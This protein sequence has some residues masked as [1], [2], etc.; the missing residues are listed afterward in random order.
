MADDDYEDKAQEAPEPKE[1][2]PESSDDVHKEA[3]ERYKRAWDRERDNINEAYEDL[4][5][6]R[7]RPED[8]WPREE[9][10]KRK[11]KRPI[12]TI[13]KIPQFIRQVTGDIR[14][15]R[16]AIRVVPV[17]SGADP[18]VAEI[19]SG[20]IRYIENRSNAKHIYTTAA[21]TQVTA[22]IGHWQVV[23]EYAAQ[24]TMNQEIRIIGIEDS[25]AVL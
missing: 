10:E 18:E 13:N 19:F 15:M 8:Q 11:G 5:F 2:K 21:D 17:D 25:I 9:L 16:P 12:L 3:M 6:R 14:Q 4:R 22:G 23:T 24:S 1:E 20:M 7:G